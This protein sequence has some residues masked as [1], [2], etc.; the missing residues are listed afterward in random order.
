MPRGLSQRPAELDQFVNY[1]CAH[2]VRSYL[3]IGARYGQTFEEVGDALQVPS[4][5]VAVDQPGAMWGRDDSWAELEA[6]ANRLRAKG[7]EVYLI[8]GDSH[9]H[10]TLKAV[11]AIRARW[12][13][14]FIDADHRYEAVLADW[15]DYGTMGHIVGFHD[16]APT[17][18]NTRIE[19]PRLWHELRAKFKGF[20]IVDPE[21][22][23]MGIGVLLPDAGA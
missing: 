8:R 14:V 5:L 21:Q 19:V 18:E 2:T 12:D 3:E 13:A 20:E 23:G 11:Q 16:I 17:P 7:H 1:L 22:P 4:V 6:A 15:Q 10:E 9:A